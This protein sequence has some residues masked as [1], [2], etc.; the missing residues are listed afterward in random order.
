MKASAN[1]IKAIGVTLELTNTQLSDGAV[2]AMLADLAAYPEDQVLG[3]LKRCCRELKS[4]LTLADVL[5]RIDD[6]RP[7]PE[8]AWSMIPRDEAAT[9]FWTPEM[10]MAYG[11]ARALLEHGDEVPARMAFIERYRILVQQARD[12]RE[13]VTWEIS[14]G[15]DKNAR[16]IAILEAAEKGRISADA[17]QRL[18]PHHREGDAMDKRLRAIA[19]KSMPLLEKAL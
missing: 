2:K 19:V 10:R 9:T 11:A 13:P 7:G 17:A 8:E 5:S 12:A 16:E 14:P 6:G 3:A 4:R 15:T 1:L 18:L